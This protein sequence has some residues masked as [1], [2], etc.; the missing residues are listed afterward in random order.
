M[1]KMIQLVQ[2]VLA[3]S[4]RLARLAEPADYEVYVR[5]TERRQ[6]LA[7]E[8]HA[9]S[10]V[11]EAEK[12]LL[13]SIGQYDKILLSHMQMLKDEAS[14]G[15]Q[16]ISGSRKLKEGYGYTGTHESIMFDKGV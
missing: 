6:V 12:V 4:D 5:L 3:E 15:I 16:R 10:T 7:E 13:S 1:D 8:V 11:S 2:E 14:S 9:R